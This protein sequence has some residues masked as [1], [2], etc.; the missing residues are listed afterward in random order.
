M[1]ADNSTSL[2]ELDYRV[3]G[4]IQVRLLWHQDD[5]RLWVAVRDEGTGESFRLEVLVGERPLDVFRH[6]Y[7]YAAHHHIDTRRPS[8]PADR[9]IEVTPSP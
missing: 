2:R 8:T 3:A 9:P 4:G 1:T 6:P 5:E 7:A